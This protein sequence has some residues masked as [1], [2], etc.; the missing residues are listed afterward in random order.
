LGDVVYDCFHGLCFQLRSG[1]LKYNTDGIGAGLKSREGIGLGS[2]FGRGE[3]LLLFQYDAEEVF[4]DFVVGF[5]RE[6]VAR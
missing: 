6:S 2:L 3:V 1:S 4:E 5:V